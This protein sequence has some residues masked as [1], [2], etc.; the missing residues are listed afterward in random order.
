[1]SVNRT[2]PKELPASGRFIYSTPDGI[3]GVWAELLSE[4]ENPDAVERSAGHQP[5]GRIKLKESIE[6]WWKGTGASIDVFQQ[7]TVID[8]GD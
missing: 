2:R 8:W 4:L 1:M 7:T 6:Q 5:C 3:R